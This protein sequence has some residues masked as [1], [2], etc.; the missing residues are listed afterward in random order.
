[1]NIGQAAKLSG[2]TAKMIR[3]YE[4]IGLIAFVKRTDAGYRVYSEQDLKTLKFI[5]H[6]REL[7]FSIEQIKELISLWKN[8]DRQSAEVK[9]LAL[10][11]ISELNEKI[12]KLQEM[13]DTLKSSIACCAGDESPECHILQNIE[14]GEYPAHT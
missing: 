7:G 11:H 4:E 8:T 1:M 12:K 2:I 9:Q 6:S 10:Q 13:V 14:L 3:Y 5:K